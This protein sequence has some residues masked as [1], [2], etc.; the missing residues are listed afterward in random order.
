MYPGSEK[1]TYAVDDMVKAWVLHLES[2]AI[3][4]YE[5]AGCGGGESGE[6]VCTEVCRG[7][8]IVGASSRGDRDSARTPNI[9]L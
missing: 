3:S 5:V 9:R 8:R 4:C 6:A 2:A 1:G 7:R